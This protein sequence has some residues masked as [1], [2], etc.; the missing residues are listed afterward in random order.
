MNTQN[1]STRPHQ[2][3]LISWILQRPLINSDTD[4][5][6]PLIN[7][8][9]YHEYLPPPFPQWA[10]RPQ[11]IPPSINSAT[12]HECS[13]CPIDKISHISWII[14]NWSTPGHHEH[15]HPPLINSDTRIPPFPPHW[16]TQPHTMNVFV[17]QLILISWI[18]FI[19]QLGHISLI[20][21]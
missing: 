10:N 8:A 6:H 17:G 12:Y 21:N 16:S 5:E 11:W 20:P 13:H 15:L 4:H 19:D 9:R 18:P 1:W 7:A 3:G 14:P 2:L